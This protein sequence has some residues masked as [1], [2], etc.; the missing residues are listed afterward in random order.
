MIR[1]NRNKIYVI[2]HKN[3]DT[4]SICSAIA[5]AHLKNQISNEQHEASRAGQIN[6]ETQF[7]LNYFKVKAPRY[8][9]D[10]RPQI[11]DIFVRQTQGISGMMSLKKAWDY[12]RGEKIVTLPIVN[13]DK[14]LE[15]VITISD[16]ATSDMDVYDSAVIS[17][18]CTPYRNIVETLN[19]EMIVGDIE[20]IYDSGK[21]II[22]AAN[23]DVMEDYIDEGD[24]VILGNRYESQLCAIEMDAKCLVVCMGAP[25]SKTIQKLAAEKDCSIII[26]PYDT[27]TV[28]RLVNHSMPVGYFM[29]K[30]NLIS[31]GMTDFT[32]D[33]QVVMAK[34]RF[35]EFP[36]LDKAGHYIG[37]VSR[38]SL[39]SMERKKLIL[40]DHN[41][42]S[43]AVD[44]Y[45]TAEIL[46][47]I[48]HHR[49]GSMETMGPVYFRNQPVGC[50]ATIITQIYRENGIEI[51][52]HIAG[53]LCSA[54]LSDTLMY[55]SPTC[56]PLDKMTAEELAKI[57]GIDVEAY[58]RDMFTAGSNLKEKTPKEI[59]HQDYK[60]FVAGDRNFGVGQITAMSKEEL[61]EIKERLIPYI[62]NSIK[63]YGVEMIFF[64]LT[65][66]LEESTELII[67]GTEATSVIQDAFAIKVEGDSV[68]LP[69]VVSR[70]KQ[71]IPPIMA[72][73]QA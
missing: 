46:E 28:A 39:I 19:G 26:T 21:V 37:M 18:A 40:V 1:K 51:P 62:E 7:V 17:K 16:I 60:K 61:A 13:D 63:E 72:L 45:E 29:T 69:G 73:L 10:V 54:I 70:K 33:V 38:R 44:G 64:M 3:P 25:V 56:T 23:P 20:K 5:Y 2:G 36:V 67:K 58:A 71:L 27:Y 22:A 34:K 49:I 35:H 42:R 8:I 47:I 12:L 48:D 55:R 50:T 24:L 52:S 53:L 59:F 68:I 14:I 6:S 11:K 41:E 30:E 43:Q 57:A 32:E 31:F 4:D 15:G 65:N 66:I 9:P